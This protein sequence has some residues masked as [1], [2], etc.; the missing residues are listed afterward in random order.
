MPAGDDTRPLARWNGPERLREE[1]ALAGVALE[2]RAC[3]PA[4][5]Q[6]APHDGAIQANRRARRIEPQQVEGESHP[7]GVHAAAAL[8]QQRVARRERRKAREAAPACPSSRGDM[9]RQ[10][11]PGI[12]ALEAAEARDDANGSPAGSAI[13]GELAGGGRR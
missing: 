7:G 3:A 1:L 2:H 8:E 4:A 12:A 13:A 9:D 5:A 10:P 6:A 11:A